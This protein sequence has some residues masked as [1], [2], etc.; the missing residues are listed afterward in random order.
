MASRKAVSLSD[1][2]P[3]GPTSISAVL[4]PR[5]SRNASQRARESMPVAA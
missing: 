1:A 2:M 5:V 3:A 4:I